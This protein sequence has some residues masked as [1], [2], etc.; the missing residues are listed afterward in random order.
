MSE[1]RLELPRCEKLD[2]STLRIVPAYTEAGQFCEA[3]CVT[4][5]DGERTA[6]YVPLRVSWQP[7]PRTDPAP[8]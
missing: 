6:I 3:N 1:P 7:T 5:T 2:G 4:I 8:A